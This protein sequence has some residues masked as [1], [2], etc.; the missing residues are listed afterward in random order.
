MDELSF[1][2]KKGNV[3][4]NSDSNDGNIDPD[5][6]LPPAPVPMKSNVIQSRSPN[7]NINGNIIPQQVLTHSH[8]HSLTHSLTDLST[9]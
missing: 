1:G 9:H 3:D 7:S 8:T 5:V 6:W 4:S 2:G